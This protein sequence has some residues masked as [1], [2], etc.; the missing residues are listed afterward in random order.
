[1]VEEAAEDAILFLTFRITL[2]VVLIERNTATVFVSQALVPIAVDEAAQ[3]RDEEGILEI[4]EGAEC[5]Y[6]G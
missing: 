2:V 5:R 4:V 3:I 6:L 1:M